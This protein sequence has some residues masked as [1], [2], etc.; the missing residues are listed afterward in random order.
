M[1]RDTA[2]FPE[3]NRVNRR[4]RVAIVAFLVASTA[5]VTATTVAAEPKP[6]VDLGAVSERELAAIDSALV[7]IAERQ[8]DDGSWVFD[9]AQPQRFRDAATALAVLSLLGRGYTDRQGLYQQQLDE[10]LAYLRGR[11]AEDGGRDVATRGTMY[12]AGLV[13]LAL[14]RAYALSKHDAVA[15]PA[16]ATLDFIAAAQDPA[17][18]GWR[19]QPRQP[20]DTSAFGWQVAALAAGAAAGLEVPMATISGATRFLDGVQGDE[21]G[22]TYGY[23]ARGNTPS[24]SAIG[25]VARTRT[26]WP[27]H[28]PRLGRGADAVAGLGPSTNLYTEFHVSQLMHILGGPRNEAWRKAVVPPLLDAQAQRGQDRGSWFDGFE[29]TAA[30]NRFYCTMLATLILE[31]PLE[32]RQPQPL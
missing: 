30:A 20:G 11:V 17:G 15:K 26:G 12:S 31:T 3:K 27:T 24:C 16:Q 1:L 29:K 25:L 32:P 28:D 4:T 2:S 23:V 19:Y 5:I 21:E 7:W 9:E 14:C 18:G 13:S 6:A 10:G 22:M 8:Q